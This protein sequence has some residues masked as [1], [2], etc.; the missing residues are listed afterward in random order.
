MAPWE[1][2]IYLYNTLTRKKEEFVPQDA[3]EV[4]MYTCGPTV[5]DYLTIGNLRAYVI[6]DLLR[7]TLEYNGYQVRQVM[8]IT[9]VGHLTSDADLG[10]DK[11]EKGSR[12]EGKSPLEIARF[13]EEAALQDMAE[14]NIQ[15]PKVICRA[16]EH[17]P[18]QIELIKKLETKGLTYVTE[19]AVYFDIAAWVGLSTKHT[20]YNQLSGKNLEE[21]LVAARGEVVADPTKKDPRDFRLWQLNQP[22]HI[23]QWDSPW[24]R[25]YPGWHLE[26][27]AMAMKYLGESFDLHTGGVDLIFPHHTNE[28]AQSEGVTNKP[29]V[30]YWVHNE[31]LLV[32]GRRMG[33]SEGNAHTLT[34][35]KKRGFHP[36]ALRYLF[37]TTHYRAKQNF[38][39]EALEAAQRA[40]ERLQVEAGGWKLEAGSWKQEA[41][42]RRE[43]F[44]EAVD[45]DLDLPKALSIVWEL[46]K[47]IHQSNSYQLLL[48]FDQ[49]LG[50]GLAHVS[51][52]E[53]EIPDEIRELVEKR[54]ESRRQKNF[55]QAD[56]I[57]QQIETKGFCVEDTEKGPTLKRLN[58]QKDVS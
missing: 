55:A 51:R 52:E 42:S 37:L 3:Q 56:K 54:E 45:D 40:L 26:C 10:E 18:E 44:Q 15:K 41:G 29:F 49:V 9:D 1:K 43:R 22:K 25:G 53:T 57:R 36:L 46:T 5:H 14:L 13:Y 2:M 11:L 6:A 23:L 20:Q 8:N 27:S 16:T 24:G 58:S 39:W 7:R 19:N 21:L 30:S 38:T 35:V 33:K 12:R 34:D 17:I 4:K 48:D 31:H 50:L 28:I 47:A 32:E